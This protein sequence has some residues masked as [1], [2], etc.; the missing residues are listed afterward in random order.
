M[1]LRLLEV[2]RGRVDTI[3][4]ARWCR[5]ILEDVPQ[6]RV[7][8]VTQNFGSPHAIARVEFGADGLLV[9]GRPETGPARA[10]LE[11]GLRIE[12]GGSAADAPIA[13]FPFQVPVFAT[14]GRLSPLLASHVILLWR[15]VLF[16]FLVGLVHF[17]LCHHTCSTPGIRF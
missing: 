14:K 6:V 11:F 1:L 12:E 9:E 4:E 8:R 15:E 2:E 3:A 16:P 13:A 17:F 10:G 7:T 5:T